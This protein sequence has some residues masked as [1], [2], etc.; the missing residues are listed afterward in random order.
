MKNQYLLNIANAM[1]ITHYLTI[2]S[3]FLHAF[4][5]FFKE[6]GYNKLFPQPHRYNSVVVCFLFIFIERFSLSENEAL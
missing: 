4:E 1:E 2:Y 6:Y 3:A 5:S